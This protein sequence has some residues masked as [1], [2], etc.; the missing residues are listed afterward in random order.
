MQATN[1]NYNPLDSVIAPYRSRLD[2]TMN[3]TVGYTDMAF[4]KA[5][6]F[7]KQGYP[8]SPL[9]NLMADLVYVETNRKRKEAGE[10]PIDISLFNVGG[11]RASLPEGAVSRGNIFELMPF[12]NQV[13]VVELTG[14][15][16]KELLTYL[17][18]KGG[19]PVSGLRFAIKN[20]S[21][22]DVRINGKPF[23]PDSDRTYLIATSDYLTGGGDD[24]TFLKNTPEMGKYGLLRDM[25]L[26]YFLRMNS[27][28]RKIHNE[29]DGRIYY[30][31]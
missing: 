29:T 13:V 18:M 24:M 21:A 12:D 17:V 1:N 8:E 6:E 22:V 31:K 3:I 10:Q 4:V 14:T 28:N 11:I 20:K 26:S 30:D 7:V 5:S 16:M 9:G 15:G 23:N 19:Q 27:E 25:I 2:S